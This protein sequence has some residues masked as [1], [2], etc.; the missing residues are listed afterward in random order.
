MLIRFI[1][2]YGDIKKDQIR[3]TRS[4]E[5]AET[6]ITSGVAEKFIATEGTKT[7]EEEA[8]RHK[9]QMDEIVAQVTE[10][11]KA[12]NKGK[13]FNQGQAD[14]K[15]G[16]KNFGEFAQCVAQGK[17]NQQ[18]MNYCKTTGMG[19]AINAD[20]GFLIPPE[21]STALLTAMAQAGQL[22]PKCRN[23]PVNNNISLPFVNIT[24]QATSWTGGI[25]VYKPAEGV[26]KTESLPQFAKAEM[27][28]HKMA[29]VCYVTD[30]LLADSPVALESFLTT[31]VSTEFA[32]TKDEDIVNGSGAGEA[33]GLMQAP[34]LVSV[35]KE[36]DQDAD[37]IV[38]PNVLKMWSRL[39]NPSRSK[40]VW[41]IAQDAMPQIAV[42]TIDVGTG[43]AP[44][45][46]AD[47]KSPLGA[48]LLGR[49]IIWCPHCQTIG[50]KGD[51]ILADFSQ[52]LTITKAGVAGMETATSIHLKFL[53]D[54]TIF[55]FVTRFDGQP[56]W[57][58][59]VTPKHG[60]NTV[61]PFI[62]LDARA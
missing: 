50:D 20:G 57:A 56:W 14:N 61:S 49:P 17:S 6:L 36:T 32:L 54:E 31:M 9:Q 51:I 23:I 1:Q 15:S 3:N 18:L 39:Y 46:I 22:A 42:L 2:D 27:H 13:N 35:G 45:F 33:L 38:T 55:R 59:A 12:E 60:S 11:L 30:E 62:T 24:T 53:E 48:S 44:V 47:L 26:A 29:A 10:Q 28:L 41:L 43:G 4:D 21:F 25:T 37:T 7:E 16:F 40:A 34:C 19:I 5:D 8:A 58:S 52:Y